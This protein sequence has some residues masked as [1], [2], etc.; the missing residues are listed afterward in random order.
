M[1]FCR[2]AVLDTSW[3]CVAWSRSALLIGA[4]TQEPCRR[5]GK[6]SRL[7]VVAWGDPGSSGSVE[8]LV[9]IQ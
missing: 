8:Q 2:M 4:A 6:K 5:A 1:V 3:T 9:S 7:W